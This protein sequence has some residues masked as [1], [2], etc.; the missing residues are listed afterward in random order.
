MPMANYT[1]KNRTSRNRSTMPAPLPISTITQPS[2]YSRE[3]V[4]K[5]LPFAEVKRVMARKRLFLSTGQKNYCYLII[6]GQVILHRD[7]DDLA[8]TTINAP[9]LIGVGNMATRSMNG[10][11]KLL[12]TS[13]IGILSLERTFDIIR[14]ND[15][16]ELLTM[17]MM[18]VTSKLYAS[19]KMLTAPTSYDIIKSQLI[20]LMS[21][22]EKY[23][24]SITAENYIRDKTNLSRSGIMRILSELKEGGYI[25]I[26]RG[27]L[28]MVH[29]LPEKF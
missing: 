22:N 24:N 18:V 28:M 7:D 20:E 29:Q 13:D 15:L 3:L 17:H 19:N 1:K 14:E 11:I 27:I 26:N 12:T 16:W 21:E 10:Y 8:M 6:S 2:P 9:S 23:R 5:L 25:E 4:D